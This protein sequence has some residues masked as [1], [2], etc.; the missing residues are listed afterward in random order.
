MDERKKYFQRIKYKNIR[1]KVCRERRLK[2]GIVIES[3][4]KSIK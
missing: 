4:N 1:N 3:K 2:I